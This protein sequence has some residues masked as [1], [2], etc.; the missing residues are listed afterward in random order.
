MPKLRP[1]KCRQA[2]YIKFHRKVVF[3][4]KDVHWHYTTRF[5]TIIWQ[6]WKKIYKERKI[7]EQ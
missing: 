3:C 5:C 6:E 2:D 7:Y 1:R 4:H